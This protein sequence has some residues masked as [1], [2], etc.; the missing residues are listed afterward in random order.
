MEHWRQP[1]KGRQNQQQHHNLQH[2]TEQQQAQ[3]SHKVQPVKTT[4]PLNHHHNPAKK[5]QQAGADPIK[6]IANVLNQH[7]KFVHQKKA[8]N[9]LQEEQQLACGSNLSELDSQQRGITKDIG[10]GGPASAAPSSAAAVAFPQGSNQVDQG[11]SYLYAYNDF[12]TYTARALQQQGDNHRPPLVG[13]AQAIGGGNGPNEYLRRHKPTAYNFDRHHQHLQLQESLIDS[14]EDDALSYILHQHRIQA[15]ELAQEQIQSLPNPSN[16]RNIDGHLNPCFTQEVESCEDNFEA[17]RIDHHL[18]CSRSS[19]PRH[20][21]GIGGG[22]NDNLNHIAARLREESQKAFALN[23]KTRN[24]VHPTPESNATSSGVLHHQLSSDELASI[25]SHQFTNDLTAIQDRL[26]AVVNPL[27][28]RYNNNT[29]LD[30]ESPTDAGAI[31]LNS[32]NEQLSRLGD[33]EGA[34][35]TA[36]GGAKVKGTSSEPIDNEIVNDSNPTSDSSRPTTL[37]TTAQEAHLHPSRK[38]RRPGYLSWLFYCLCNLFA[39][40]SHQAPIGQRA[41][42]QYD[43][44]ILSATGGGRRRGNKKRKTGN[45]GLHASEASILHT[46]YSN[47]QQQ[48]LGAALG[49]LGGQAGAYY[50]TQTAPQ[51]TSAPSDNVPSH[52]HHHKTHAQQYHHHH[53]PISS[54]SSLSSSAFAKSALRM[55]AFFKSCCSRKCLFVSC[56]MLI[57]LIFIFVIGLSAY[58]NF[59][60]NLNKTSLAPLSGRLRVDNQGDTFTDQL[61]NRTS[62]EFLAKQQ[63]YETILRGAFDRTQN[64]LKTYPNHLVKCEVYNFKQGS[65]W[66]YFRLFINKRTLLHDTQLMKRKSPDEHLEKQ[67]LPRLTQQT[68]HSGFEQLVATFNRNLAAN[69]RPISGR[70]ASGDLLRQSRTPDKF[71]NVLTT[72][73]DHVKSFD[74]Q[75]SRLMPVI[76]SI[77]LQSIT[78]TPEFDMLQSGNAVQQQQPQQSMSDNLRASQFLT[79][80]SSTVMVASE[81]DK[82]SAEYDFGST[83][84][85]T[86]SDG[87]TSNRSTTSPLASVARPTLQPALD[88]DPTQTGSSD[89]VNVS[90]KKFT[91][92]GYKENTTRPTTSIR[93]KANRPE[94]ESPFL[95]NQIQKPVQSNG[96]QPVRH[97]AEQNGASAN[98]SNF[99]PVKMQEIISMTKPSEQ[100]ERQPSEKEKLIVKLV[101]GQPVVGKSSNLQRATTSSPEVGDNKLSL[102]SNEKTLID[103]YRVPN[104]TKMDYE[105]LAKNV[106]GLQKVSLSRG[107]N[108]TV[109]IP[110]IAPYQKI[111]FSTTRA[112]QDVALSP[113]SDIEELW[114]KALSNSSKKNSSSSARM[115]GGEQPRRLITI[116]ATGGREH[117]NYSVN[118]NNPQIGLDW[119]KVSVLNSD[120][121]DT[122]RAQMQNASMTSTPILVTSLRQKTANFS[123]Q[124]LKPKVS[125]HLKQGGSLISAPLKQQE[126]SHSSV[127]L[128]KDFK[129]GQAS[130]SMQPK[131]SPIKTDKLDNRPASGG[132]VGQRNTSANDQ[133]KRNVTKPIIRQT[134]HKLKKVVEIIQQQSLIKNE[135]SLPN[136]T[137]NGTLTGSKGI[138]IVDQFLASLELANRTGTQQQ[139]ELL[140]DSHQK[141]RTLETFGYNADHLAPTQPTT[142]ELTRSTTPSAPARTTSKQISG[143]DYATTSSAPQ[144]YLASSLPSATEGP[145]KVILAQSLPLPSRSHSNVYPQSDRL[146]VTPSSKFSSQWKPINTDNQTLPNVDTSEAMQAKNRHLSTRKPNSLVNERSQVNNSNV[147]SNSGSQSPFAMS[148]SILDTEPTNK[149]STSQIRSGNMNSVFTGRRPA[150]N[151]LP[152]T[153]QIV[154]MASA[155]SSSGVN[156]FESHRVSRMRQTELISPSSLEVIGLD[157]IPTSTSTSSIESSSKVDRFVA[158]ADG[159]GGSM[160]TSNLLSPVLLST[161]RANDLVAASPSSGLINSLDMMP[162]RTR[163]PFAFETLKSLS[164][165]TSQ[166]GRENPVDGLLGDQLA[167]HRLGRSSDSKLLVRKKLFLGARNEDNFDLPLR[168]DEADKSSSSLDAGSPVIVAGVN[169]SVPTIADRIGN[170]SKPA[171]NYQKDADDQDVEEVS[172]SFNCQY[173]GCKAKGSVKFMCLNFTQICDDFIDC[174]DESDELDCVSLLKYDSR[175]NRLSF[176]NGGGIIY[177]NRKGSLAPMCIDYFGQT[178]KIPTSSLVNDSDVNV[179]PADSG[180]KQ[181]ELIKQINTIGQYACSLQSFS[182]LVSVKIN[183]H[184]LVDSLNL[185]K[186]SR[187][188]HRL[189]I[190]ERSDKSTK[191]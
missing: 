163:G 167:G 50:P 70:S 53:Y 92:Y 154:G 37:T 11:N 22:Q 64:L 133:Q 85:V 47:S 4:S 173:Y 120:I 126:S 149:P 21:C 1:D 175:N 101:S 183:H 96:Q 141:N 171:K 180:K 98:S 111:D 188:Y 63:Q 68:L 166:L 66:V 38:Q 128:S 46:M 142:I 170:R 3:H 74:D 185:I 119:N 107:V 28:Y 23:Q 9:R 125:P 17:H 103:E 10:G 51:S 160:R 94:Y 33:T 2:R 6:S 39:S 16:Y 131:S 118:N 130:D 61:M 102:N 150:N 117:Q 137:A 78:V 15:H 164:T 172:Q 153:Y 56:L 115:D 31:Y 181:L 57:L 116:T 144:R 65:L 36:R 145:F 26:A 29:H 20:I 186:N 177:L 58:L 45:R 140:A 76:E 81:T 152:N 8:Q 147:P 24:S 104:T 79:T 184:D 27:A 157:Q 109:A 49:Q 161:L 34:A 48:Q 134:S 95:L 88:V 25:Q 73:K 191:Q 84:S 159:V 121:S 127:A 44:N 105:S 124:T 100:L 114:N 60:I 168:S 75:I 108:E 19:H 143:I 97:S 72:Q 80:S 62:K 82:N 7:S 59:L 55:N 67:F 93:P 43:S 113:S 174:Q 132:F 189:S 138:K 148:P 129:Q 83:T 90:T 86:S 91:L 123:A 14:D 169:S 89:E 69:E 110:M 13:S 54:D 190:I 42:S 156:E 71:R 18:S 52:H 77:D 30:N 40:S 5:H 158:T 135:T 162:K 178:D 182:R 32:N 155:S 165:Q 122:I 146:N 179:K 87:L 12:I 139:I 35:L 136:K 176:S 99:K 151:R 187:L 41:R 112:S 106:G